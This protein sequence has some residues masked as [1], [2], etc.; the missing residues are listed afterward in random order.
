MKFN[1]IAIIVGLVFLV[2]LNVNLIRI[3]HNSNKVLSKYKEEIKRLDSPKQELSLLKH[4]FELKAENKDPL[5]ALSE[6]EKSCLEEKQLIIY[7]PNNA[8]S[9]CVEKLFGEYWEDYLVDIKEQIVV[10]YENEHLNN[11]YYLGEGLVDGFYVDKKWNNDIHF[12]SIYFFGNYGNFIS[13]YPYIEEQLKSIKPLIV[14]FTKSI[15][16]KTESIQIN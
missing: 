11:T 13:M 10:L 8:C 6:E 16:A 5:F 14:S 3:N 2:G 12:I 1:K 9:L 15:T 7:V 4:V